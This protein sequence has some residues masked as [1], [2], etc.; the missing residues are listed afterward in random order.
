MSKVRVLV[1][2]DSLTIRRRLCEV[3]SADP[4][5]EVVG[6]AEDG[7]LAIELCLAL[8]PNV[9]TLDMMLPTL[10]GLAVTEYI[11]AHQPTP[12]LVVSAS[13]NRGELFK[14][15]E[16][17]AAGAIEVMEKPLAD[18][19]DDGWERRFTSMVKLVARVVPITHVRALRSPR[20]GPGFAPVPPFH[21]D[22]RACE[23][24]AIGA[25]TGGPRA[26][27]EVLKALPSNLKLP[28]LLVVHIGTPFGAS[29]AEWLDGQTAHRVRFATEGQPISGPGVFLAP[30]DCHLVV[31]Q[32]RL[33]LSR[34]P[35]R[36]SCRPSVDVLF[37]SV[38]I[39][40]GATAAACLLTGMGHDGAHGL[41]MIRQAG[42][43][44]I[45]QDEASSVVYGMPREAVLL[46]A[47][48]SVLPLAEIGPALA[49]LAQGSRLG[50]R[51]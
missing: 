29:F 45:A 27:V 46:N 24:I 38:A 36:H 2:E 6:D 34:G 41:L 13:T 18:D 25:S 8:R 10:N 11:M 48:E 17:L 4:D 5:I 16:A 31:Q 44:T 19:M 9:M 26:V 51:S 39:A 35:E 49:A 33:H 12:I 23:L 43:F 40:C 50:V 15:Y 32:R 14:T 37:E 21:P 42:G 47:A 20:P 7:N 28:V 30:P 22:G 3:L 1:V